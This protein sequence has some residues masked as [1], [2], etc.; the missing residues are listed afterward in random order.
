VYSEKG[1][2]MPK[3]ILIKGSTNSHKTSSAR[4]FT[5]RYVTGFSYIG[6]EPGNPATTLTAIPT[7]GDF[8]AVG[9]CTKNG[10]PFKIGVGSA[11]DDAA[12]IT[13]NLN[14]FASLGLGVIVICSKSSGQSSDAVIHH[15][16]NPAGLFYNSVFHVTTT[17]RFSPNSQNI[18]VDEGR[19]AD[20]VFAFI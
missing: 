15:I 9:T 3:L 14:Y 8:V 16:Y 1:L 4:N 2:V 5:L 10:V 7:S 20:D 13:K 17:F 19:V 12:R 6:I 18:I 11:G